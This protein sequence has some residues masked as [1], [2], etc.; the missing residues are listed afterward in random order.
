MTVASLK[1]L[2]E[3]RI[4]HKIQSHPDVAAK[5]NA[6]YQFDVAGPD[7]GCWFV[8]LQTPG[9]RVEA[10][11]SP[12]AGCTIAMKDADL[13]AM[14]NGKLSP[15]MAFMTGKIKIKGDYG[16]AMKLQQVL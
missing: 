3:E 4:P 7:G 16:L 2:F 15:S 8:D 12:D 6:V 10:G 11:T 5:I 9:G 14:V 1:E 13:L